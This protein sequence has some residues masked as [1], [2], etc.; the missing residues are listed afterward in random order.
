MAVFPF[1][2]YRF[3]FLTIERPNSALRALLRSRG[4]VYLIDHGCFGD[5]LWAHE[6]EAEG[7]ARKLGVAISRDD[8]DTCDGLALSH[9]SVDHPLQQLQK[10]P[11][12]P[13]FG[14]KRTPVECCGKMSEEEMRTCVL[15]S[16]A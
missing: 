5:Q 7:A 16:A 11:C 6:S 3:R 12:Q 10:L 8:H 13:K 14:G 9:P 1:E 2:R 4:Y 15:G